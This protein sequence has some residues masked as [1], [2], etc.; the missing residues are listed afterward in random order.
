MQKMVE[1]NEK[2]SWSFGELEANLAVLHGI[3]SSK[4]TAFQ[5]RLKHL[6]RLGFPR[7]FRTS[8]GKASRYHV[9]A[10]FQMA[11]VLEMIQCGFPPERSIELVHER[12]WAVMPALDRAISQILAV[13]NAKNAGACTIPE[14]DD[15]VIAV[16]PMALAYLT[17]D[18]DHIGFELSS[19]S[20]KAIGKEF[21]LVGENRRL[22]LI[23]LSDLVRGLASF[24]LFGEPAQLVYQIKF[25]TELDDW[26]NRIFEN[27]G[28]LDHR[29]MHE[30]LSEFD[31]SK[32]TKGSVD[33]LANSILIALNT[34]NDS[35]YKDADIKKYLKDFGYLK[36]ES[37]T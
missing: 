18:I 25:L 3:T 28:Y 1:A 11:F 22:L 23:N 10:I 13:V 26:L 4:R 33:E 8:Q 21:E 36:S 2:L 9:G 30:I 29:Y 15:V 7:G 24:P 17:T 34:M 20:L 31:W 32:S 35:K 19:V 27:E 5:A 37:L 14:P 6:H 12:W 16:T